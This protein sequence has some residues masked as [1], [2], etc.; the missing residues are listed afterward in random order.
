MA[1][2]NVYVNYD[3][4]SNYIHNLA[5]GTSAQDAATYAQ[6]TSLESSMMKCYSTTIGDGSA[7][8]FSVSHGLST[9]NVIVQVRMT[10]SPYTYITPSSIEATG[11]ASVAI[12]FS[13]APTSA[14]Y[15]VIIIG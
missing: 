14:E 7:T 4:N 9:Q 8:S 15:T 1:T 12:A 3:M 13:S 5:D 6:I 2:T 11:T 10:A